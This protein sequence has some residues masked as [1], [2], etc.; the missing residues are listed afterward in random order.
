M[1]LASLTLA[2]ISSI[3]VYAT[4]A[5]A[6]V[7]VGGARFAA[8]I[9]STEPMVLKG[10]GVLRWK[11]LIRAYAAALYLPS[12]VSTG[13]A[14]DDVPK[15]LE[16]EYFWAIDGPDFG[17]AADQLLVDR[18]GSEGVAPLRTRLDAL[19]QSYES[20]EPGDRYALTYRPGVGTELS[21]NGR[22]LTVIPGSD[23]ATAYFGL[24]LGD[25]PIDSR[26]RDDLRGGQSQR[27][28]TE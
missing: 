21:K 6:S 16:I 15:R 9:E 8:R 10:S 1:R 26:L 14:L 24:W 27:A 5:V 19:H 23:F 12:D 25:Q 2:A 17:R 28:R 22:S 4:A 3:G 11:S 7:D 18:L 20:V 13:G